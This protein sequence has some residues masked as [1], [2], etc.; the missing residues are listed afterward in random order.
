MQEI[1][2]SRYSIRKRN[3]SSCYYITWTELGKSKRLSTGCEIRADAE[4]FLAQFIAGAIVGFSPASIDVNFICDKYLDER[5]GKVRSYDS[6]KYALAHVKRLLGLLHPDQLAPAVIDDYKNQRKADGASDGSIIKEICILRA[7]LKLAK[8]NRIISDLP[9]IRMPV[10]T[11]PP[12]DRWLTKQEAASLLKS[13]KENHLK[14]YVILALSTLSRNGAMLE[15]KWENVDLECAIVDFGRGHGNKRRASVPI[16]DQL[17][18]ALKEALEL[19]QTDYVI[20]FR[21]KPV[22]GIKTGFK[23]ACKAANLNDVT[24][25]TLRHTGATWMAIAGVPMSEIARY[26]GDSIATTERVYAKF[27][28]DYLRKASKALSF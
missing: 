3:G 26:L 25:H 19:A 22:K 4:K 27:H 17:M 6:L 23:R 10:P 24:P 28:P 7:A 18:G 16:N 5:K 1:D 21:G 13:C 11:P 12:R 8:I 2:K 15:L 20:E 14:L 9:I